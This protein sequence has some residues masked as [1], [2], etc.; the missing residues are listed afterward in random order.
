MKPRVSIPQ[1]K[2]KPSKPVNYDLV[3]HIQM[4]YCSS[5]TLR[6]F[7][8]EKDGD[9]LVGEELRNAAENLKRQMS[10][11]GIKDIT[12]ESIREIRRRSRRRGRLRRPS[13]MRRP[14][15]HRHLLRP[16]G[17]LLPRAA[18]W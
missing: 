17:T 9:D 5:R 2:K 16:P 14:Q 18:A 6:D 15:G 8:D 4:Q 11:G 10:S 1:Q 3:L 12:G 13:G 7:L